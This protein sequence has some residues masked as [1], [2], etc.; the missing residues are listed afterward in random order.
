MANDVF[1]SYSSTDKAAADAV[2]ATLESRGIGCWI[3]P[4]DILP[5]EDYAAGAGAGAPRQPLDDLS[6]SRR[7]ANLSPQVLRE[8]ERA[9]S[10]GLDDCAASHRRRGPQ[11][12]QWSTTFRAVSGSTRRKRP[13]IS[14]SGRFAQT[15]RA[16]AVP[17]RNFPARGIGPNQ[18]HRRHKGNAHC[19]PDSPQWRPGLLIAISLAFLFRREQNVNANGRAAL[20]GALTE[21]TAASFSA[22]VRLTRAGDASLFRASRPLDT[23]RAGAPGRAFQLRHRRLNPRVTQCQQKAT[24]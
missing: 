4:R 7:R 17:N 1:I 12:R 22:G 18:R 10:K 2:C 9:V 23:A 5:G 13:S 15:V 21:R 14:T 16:A 6:C 11:P 3:A 8:V 20:S 24:H 19:G